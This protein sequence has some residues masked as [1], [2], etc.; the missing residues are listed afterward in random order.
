MHDK[1]TSRERVLR[2]I[3]GGTP[4]RLPF[5]FWMDRDKMAEYDAK[6]GADFRLTHYGADVIEAFVTLP[7]WAGLEMKSIDDGKTVWQTEPL[8]QSMKDAVNLPMPDPTD[9]RVY[10]DV[11]T[12]RAANPD[13][14]VFAMMNVPLG[15]LEPLR[16]AE[17]LFLDLYDSAEE[18]HSVL[19]RVKPVLMEAA[20]RVCDMDIDVL[21]L[22]YDICSRDGAMVSPQHLREFHFD[23]MKEVIDIAHDAGKK[24]IYHS[25]GFILPI[26]DIYV[27][28]GIDGCNPLEPR[29]NDAEEFAARFGDKLVL[30]GGGDNCNVISDGN[31]EDVR[32]HVRSRFDILGRNAR[33]IFS[34]HDIPGHCPQENLDAMVDEIRACRY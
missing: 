31:V 2:A 12:K 21:Y 5:N 20:L 27:E 19:G 4:D 8:V 17:N 13:T 7:F 18:I 16:L 14:A 11:A 15:V 25:D 34:T 3:N 22:A 1:M 28:Y 33:F 23:Y 29:Y 6:W 26:L 24:V 9:P 32:E 10:A 30:Y